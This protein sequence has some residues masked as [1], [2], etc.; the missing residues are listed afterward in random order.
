M[1][2]HED[3]QTHLVGRTYGGVTLTAGQVVIGPPEDDDVTPDLVV[4][5]VA[6]P[7]PV[8]ETFSR[9]YGRPNLTVVVRSN[10]GSPAEAY[11]VIQGL[12]Y[13]LTD[14]ANVTLGAT[15]FLR[16]EPLSFPDRLRIDSKR[17]WD[18]TC[19][20]GVW[21]DDPRDAPVV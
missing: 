1:T 7:G 17:R 13:D 5:L 9:V 14:L 2:W 21:L 18:Y 19:E 4:G 11:D 8:D 15:G 3:L 16:F 10:P 20:L 6:R 12:F